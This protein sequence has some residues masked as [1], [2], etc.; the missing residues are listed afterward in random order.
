MKALSAAIP[1]ST[2]LWVEWVGQSEN[3]VRRQHWSNT[4]KHNLAAKD[5]WLASLRSSPLAIDSL[6][7]IIRSLA[8]TKP[9]ETP[10]PEASASTTGIPESAGNTDKSE[11]MD[12]KGPS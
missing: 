4:H 9:C 8:E 3:K 2:L 7:M 1:T 6:T 5:A 11:P 12:R 10:S